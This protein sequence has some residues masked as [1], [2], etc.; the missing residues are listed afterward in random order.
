MIVK[1]VK[2]SIKINYDYYNKGHHFENILIV[3]QASMKNKI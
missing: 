3:I 1:E 2:K